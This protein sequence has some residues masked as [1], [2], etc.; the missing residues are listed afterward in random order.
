MKS[1]GVITLVFTMAAAQVSAHSQSPTS[2]PDGGRAQLE[3]VI[4]VLGQMLQSGEDELR[5]VSANSSEIASASDLE[6]ESMA[7]YLKGL[8]QAEASQS[9]TPQM[10]AMLQS[11]INAAE[12][13]VAQLESERG[14]AQERKAQMETLA[15]GIQ[16]GTAAVERMRESLKSNE[17]GTDADSSSNDFCQL[18]RVVQQLRENQLLLT[19]TVL[20]A[21][22]SKWLL[23]AASEKHFVS[24]LG[25]IIEDPNTT[26][27]ERETSQISRDIHSHKDSLLQA[28]LETARKQRAAV[29]LR[30][31][32]LGQ[33]EGM[34]CP[35]VT[36]QKL[37]SEVVGLAP[38]LEKM[39]DDWEQMRL[40]VIQ[41]EIRQTDA[42]IQFVTLSQENLA[43]KVDMWKLSPGSSYPMPA[44]PLDPPADVRIKALQQQREALVK[45]EEQ[46][47]AAKRVAQQ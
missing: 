7:R 18:T 39:G 13:S 14:L 20:A 4:E 24:A 1:L 33:E 12:E 29:E 11:D 19:Q 28:R 26:Q 30:V 44:D 21:S 42:S 2:Q 8:R 46:L 5:Q 31:K 40:R 36:P 10:R 34:P 38:V 22:E 16:S 32:Q 45:T 9:A 6:R 41:D 17:M 37:S 27:A 23:E 25:Y 3:A 43:R 15:D 35:V 47:S